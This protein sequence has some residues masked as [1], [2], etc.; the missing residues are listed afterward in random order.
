MVSA[1]LYS[2]SVH[3]IAIFTAINAVDFILEIPSVTIQVEN[4]MRSH[5]WGEHEGQRNDTAE[6]LPVW[7]HLVFCAQP[8]FLPH[9]GFHH[10]LTLGSAIP[11]FGPE[12]LD[13]TLRSAGFGAQ[14]IF[15]GHTGSLE[16]LF[17]VWHIWQQITT[18]PSASI[19]STV[20]SAS[21]QTPLGRAE[22]QLITGT[23]A[24]I[25]HQK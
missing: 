5:V 14:S 1:L 18:F 23:F 8:W 24:E 15:A 6:R 22:E 17:P 13:D 3:N 4:L 2:T 21:P 12:L 20:L 9:L 19:F 7:L 16:T 10:S 11:R 25:S